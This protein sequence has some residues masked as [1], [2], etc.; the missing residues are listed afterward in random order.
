MDPEAVVGCEDGTVR[1]CDM[2]S[3]SCSRIIRF[4]YLA[5]TFILKFSCIGDILL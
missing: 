4:V 3:R 1:V 5:R 2:Y